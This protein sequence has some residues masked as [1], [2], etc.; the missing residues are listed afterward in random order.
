MTLQQIFSERL[1][2]LKSIP[3]KFISDTQKAEK[4][5]IS[6]ILDAI[7]QLEVK[8]GLIV[9][10]KRNLTAIAQIAADIKSVVLKSD[11]IKAV[12]EFIG[13]FDTQAE[14]TDKYFNKL[15]AGAPAATA[16]VDAVL[17][18]SKKQTV[19]YLL[20]A[21][22]DSAFITPIEDLLTT[23][24]QAGASFTQT[25]KDIR[26]F[27]EDSGKEGGKLA[28]YSKQIAY[29]SFAVSDRTY[30]NQR[31]IDLNFDE[32][33][34]YDGV[35]LPTSRP[36]CLARKGKY[37]HKKEIESFV[38]KSGSIESNP[39]PR[40]EWAGM[41]PGT[42]KQ[43]IFDLAGGFQ[44]HDVISPVSIKSVPMDVIQRNIDNGNYQPTEKEME[45][46]GI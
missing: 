33:W 42:N 7:N 44:C 4:E 40:G 6:G 16:Y 20:E 36:F 22:M 24:I 2:R 17:E 45:L 34:L 26:D 35:D 12:K 25:I 10:S 3:D 19:K 38:T 41:I 11:Y 30:L 37:Y 39:L 15:I 43:T 14:L 31:A 23:N 13:E 5:I 27:I 8:G 28:Q 18:L 29:D 46:L 21:P 9:K 32:W 1:K